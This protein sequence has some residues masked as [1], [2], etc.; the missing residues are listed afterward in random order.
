MLCNKLYFAL[1]ALSLY[2]YVQA[3]TGV[4]RCAVRGSLT[5]CPP[6]Q[7]EDPTS[8]IKERSEVVNKFINN[9]YAF[10]CCFVAIVVHRPCHL[11][12]SR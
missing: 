11:L 1:H 12:V 9:Y 8:T 10:I 6:D 5:S 3:F 7:I 4:E 2:T